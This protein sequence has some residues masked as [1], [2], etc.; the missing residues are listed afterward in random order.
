MTASRAGRPGLSRR[1]TRVTGDGK[2]KRRDVR[3]IPSVVESGVRR[4]KA[5]ERTP[6]DAFWEG[7]GYRQ[8][9]S[10]PVPDDG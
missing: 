3:L 2:F 1:Q 7:E 10:P 4:K 9:L 8:I 6:T 5:E